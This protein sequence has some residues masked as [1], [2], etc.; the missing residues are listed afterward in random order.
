MEWKSVVV[1]DIETAEPKSFNVILLSVFKL[2][3]LIML[4]CPVMPL[5]CYLAQ[6][7]L[8]ATLSIPRCSVN[9]VDALLQCLTHC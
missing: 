4:K 3:I 6:K 1:S 2:N 9:V 8:R 7:F 5:Q